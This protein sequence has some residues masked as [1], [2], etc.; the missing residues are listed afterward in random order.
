VLVIDSHTHIFPPHFRKVRRALINKDRTFANLYFQS[1]RILASANDLI[2][3][4]DLSGVDV[5]VAA[6]IGWT[7][8]GAA[9]QAND[10]LI[11]SVRQYPDRLIGLCAINPLW[12]SDAIREIYRCAAA[13]LRGVGELHPD[14][15]GFRADDE[16][17][18]RPVMMA[19]ADLGL[20]VL[21]HSSEPVGHSYPGKGWTHPSSLLKFIESF[22][23]NDI[24]CAHWGGG[25]PFYALMPEVH[26]AFASVYFDSA[27]SPLI[28]SDQVFSVVEQLVGAERL[29]FG[30]DFPLLR[31]TRLLRQ[32]EE[33]GLA[34][35]SK[36]LLMGGNA[37]RLFQ[38]DSAR[39]VRRE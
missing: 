17:V 26:D 39:V 6:G 20:P 22:Q 3:E 28:Y 29:L 9:Q 7:D 38:L 32:I 16:S 25:L 23:S 2:C 31:Q 10:Y 18:L 33:S 4:M 36:I 34:N 30:S 27:A 12:G 5:S 13:G 37:A 19:A 15:Q 14:S 8:L 35:E 24:I 1:D 21:I 11:A